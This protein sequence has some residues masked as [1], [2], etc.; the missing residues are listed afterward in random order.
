MAPTVGGGT[1][2]ASLAQG[3]V[4][5]EPRGVAALVSA[6][7]APT[8]LNLMKLARALAA[9]CTV[10]LKPAPATPLE[11]LL[12]GEV[13]DAAGLPP[14]VLSIVTGDV[15]AGPLARYSRDRGAGRPGGAEAGAGTDCWPT[16]RLRQG[17]I[18][19]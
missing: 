8:M 14:G 2:G 10:V 5:R 3:V 4:R 1:F 13:A 7:N 18:E 9:G 19:R 17:I 11:T 6:Y 15:A 12:L 16:P